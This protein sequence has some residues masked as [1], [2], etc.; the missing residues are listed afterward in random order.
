LEVLYAYTESRIAKLKMVALAHCV[1]FVSTR[2][3]LANVLSNDVYN[4]WWTFMWVLMLVSIFIT[5][6][7]IL[8]QPVA[9]PVTLRA[10]QE[11]ETTQWNRLKDIV[12][13]HFSV[14]NGALLAFLSASAVLLLVNASVALWMLTYSYGS[15]IRWF[16]YIFVYGHVALY[17]WMGIM[18]AMSTKSKW[19]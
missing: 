16:S 11:S 17:L 6:I 13:P 8:F 7:A 9:E 12:H 4:K 14:Y 18:T 19:A 2:M 5:V 15:C 10:E 1:V 3:L